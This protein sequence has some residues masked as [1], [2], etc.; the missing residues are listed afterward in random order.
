MSQPSPPT[1]AS[2]SRNL[3]AAVAVVAD[4]TAV[5][6][7]FSATSGAIVAV[8]A[9]LA[10]LAGIYVMVRGWGETFG[11][12]LLLGVVAV[13]AG[14]S[15]LSAVVIPGLLP[16]EPAPDPAPGPS[17]NG[18]APAAAKSVAVRLDEGT[19]ADLDEGKNHE[20][21]E[22]DGPNGDVDLW[23]GLGVVGNEV[24]AN[25]SDFARDTEL[26]KGCAKAMS[27]TDLAPKL[28]ANSLS[29]GTHFCFRTSAGSLAMGRV[30][31]V[32]GDY[33]VLNVTVWS[34]A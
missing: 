30:N 3:L 12:R 17:Q 21:V 29:P 6:A 31:D 15:T 34:G 13:V 24:R 4:L 32:G 27:G 10:L 16:T 28:Y 9:A 5:V 20:P 19:A 33:L 8:L 14:A 25:N 22:T 11:R 23:F 2:R 7:L 1:P 18:T 26:E